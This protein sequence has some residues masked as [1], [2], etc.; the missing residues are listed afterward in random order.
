M[1]GIEE[2]KNTKWGTKLINISFFSSSC[3][4]KERLHFHYI[5]ILNHMPKSDPNIKHCWKLT[6]WLKPNMCFGHI[7]F[8]S[9]L[10]AGMLVASAWAWASQPFVWNH[11]N[12]LNSSEGLGQYVVQWWSL[13]VI[14]QFW[15]FT[16]TTLP[17]SRLWTLTIM[18]SKPSEARGCSTNTVAII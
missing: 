17:S 13:A 6:F 5:R 3:A 11:I 8:V 1:L 12:P 7:N 10:K 4:K 14:P 16:I 9:L 18:F 15:W 2:E